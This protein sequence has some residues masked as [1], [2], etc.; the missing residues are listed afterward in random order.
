MH[1]LLSGLFIGNSSKE[2]GFKKNN[3]DHAGF[4][5]SA[6]VPAPAEA[7]YT[8]SKRELSIAI[9][10]YEESKISG[11]ETEQRLANVHL[12]EH[13]AFHMEFL[14]ISFFGKG[15]I[16]RQRGWGEGRSAYFISVVG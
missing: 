14:G 4:D 13:E 2:Q 12:D 11:S 6:E 10:E 9:D 1:P 3:S 8:L 5:C 16:Q 15:K 7:L